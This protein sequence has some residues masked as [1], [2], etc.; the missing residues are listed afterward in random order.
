MKP[1]HIKTPKLIIRH[2]VL[3]DLSDFII[4][5]SNPEVTKYQG[6]D[7]M[8]IDQ[9]EDFIKE[10]S[11]KYFGNP[12]E[13]VQYAIENIETGKLIGDC[14]IKLDQ[15]DSRIAEAGITISHLEQKKGYA[16]EVL[17]GILNFLFDEIKVH[18]VVEIVDAE[19]TASINLL[20]SIGFREEGHFI[21]NIFFKGKWGSEFQFAMLKREWDDKNS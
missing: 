13:W 7:V 15:Y 17:L 2:L 14:A 4:Y 8:T 19:N 21:E 20:K 5:R 3:S 11:G 6:F 9:A 16:K 10:N 18:R 1:L 12:G